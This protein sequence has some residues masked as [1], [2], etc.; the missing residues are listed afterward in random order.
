LEW[1]LQLLHE[2]YWKLQSR[3]CKETNYER[4]KE[5]VRNDFKTIILPKR[6]YNPRLET[7]GVTIIPVSSVSE[8]HQ[9][10]DR[11]KNIN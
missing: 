11:A 10:F 7:P 1:P 2:T 4:V 3:C 8:L 9:V 5:A 6:N